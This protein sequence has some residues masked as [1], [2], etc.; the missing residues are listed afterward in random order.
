M[1]IKGAAGKPTEVAVT[2]FWMAIPRSHSESPIF[3]ALHANNIHVEDV[4][5]GP[6]F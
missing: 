3:H 5:T 6:R 4:S 2:V 1:F